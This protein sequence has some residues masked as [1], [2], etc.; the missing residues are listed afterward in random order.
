MTLIDEF[1]PRFDFRERH[2]AL[3]H[4]P[5]NII[6]DCVTRQRAQDDPLVRLAIS[7]RELPSRLMKR[8]RKRPL[9]LD[10]FT[11]LG[12]EGD[13]GV[14]FGLTGAF[15]LADYGLL[16]IESPE[17]FK[18]SARMDVCQLVMS[19]NVEPNA[20]GASMLSTETRVFC[21][22]VAVHRRFAPYWYLIRPVSGLIRRRMLARIRRQAE[23]LAAEG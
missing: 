2:A 21:P 12:R 9:D 14:A 3:I 6:L 1:M 18:A 7:L 22:T 8:S 5:A 20:S 13:R 11:F 23:S 15:W 17:A 10:D 19:F 16:D 4:A